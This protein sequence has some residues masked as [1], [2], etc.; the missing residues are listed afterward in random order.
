MHILKESQTIIPICPFSLLTT[1]MC[2]HNH[3]ADSEYTI[4]ESAA[5]VHESFSWTAYRL[6][7]K[8]EKK[9]IILCIDNFADV[10]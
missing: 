6:I 2:H 8:N 5:A 7:Q 4:S 3:F 1:F 9:N 10:I